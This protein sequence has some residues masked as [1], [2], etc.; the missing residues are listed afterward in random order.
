MEEMGRGGGLLSRLARLPGAVA[1]VLVLLGWLVAPGV[2]AQTTV[3]TRTV[4][5][6]Y[7]SYGQLW[8]LVVEPT[9]DVN[10]VKS[11]TTYTRDAATGVVTLKQLQYHDPQDGVDKTVALETLDYSGEPRYRYPLKITNALN[12]SETRSYDEGSGN[13]LSLIGPNNL[14]PTTWQYD[15]WG[16]KTLESRVDGS[17]TSWD[18]RQCVDTCLNGAVSVS[19]TQNWVGTAQAPK[20]SQTTVPSETFTDPLGRSV[21]TRSWGFGGTAIL[22]ENIYNSL[23]WLDHSSRPYYAGA[24]AIYSYYGYDSLGRLQQSQTPNDAG[25]GYDTTT[26]SYSGQSTTRTNAKN[27]TRTEVRNA[28]GKLKSVTDA[29]SFTTS[30]VYDGFGNLL[31]TTDPRGNQILVT[32][33]KLG[34][35]TNL[36]DP[37]LGAWQYSVNPRG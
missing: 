16:R 27:Q 20:T 1:S 28:L 36:V 31:Q 24:S 35:K 4:G 17:A 12:Q 8:T 22:S 15:G 21:L 19:I 25:T 10:T 7:D 34:R 3:V 29:A 37:D 14:L 33:D 11:T 18:Y 23:G 9:G 13:L 2:S 30:Y 32:Y 26:I 5:F 6:T